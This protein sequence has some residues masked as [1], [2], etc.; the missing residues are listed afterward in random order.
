MDRKTTIILISLIGALV[1]IFVFISPLW[2]SIKVLREEINQQ[3]LAITATEELLVKT[4]ALNQEYQPLAEQAQ[5][6]SLALPKEKDIPYLLVQFE[7]LAS[8]NGLLLESMDFSQITSKSEIEEAFQLGIEQSK[9]ISPLFSSLSL[10]VKVSGSYN[11]FKGYLASLEN[12]VRSMD[13]HS[14]KFDIPGEGLAALSI[15]E[16]DLGVNVYYHGF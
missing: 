8:S 4:Q 6:I 7:N 16:F 10:K 1:L 14:I 2:S 12:S 15:F 13:V 3:K 11:A 9:K 5:E